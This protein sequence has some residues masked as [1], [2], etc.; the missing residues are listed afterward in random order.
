[1]WHFRVWILSA[2]GE[3]GLYRFFFVKS[4]FLVL[5][6]DE[7]FFMICFY[8]SSNV[9]LCSCGLCHCLVLIFVPFGI[10]IG[11]EVSSNIYIVDRISQ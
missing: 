3:D 4:D 5:V 7:V 9:F 6:I 8:D 10:Q 2:K 11:K 1:M